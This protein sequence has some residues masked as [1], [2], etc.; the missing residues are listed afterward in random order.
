[1]RKASVG[2]IATLAAGIFGA[3]SAFAQA[4]PQGGPLPPLPQSQP[5]PGAQPQ[6][7]PQNYPPPPAQGYPPPPNGLRSASAMVV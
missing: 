4:P 7:P 2:A 1:M 3:A 5:Q 6:P